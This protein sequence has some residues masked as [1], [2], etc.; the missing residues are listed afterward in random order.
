MTKK[1]Y[2]KI[3][4]LKHSAPFW[5]TFDKLGSVIGTTLILTYTFMLG[6]YPHDSVYTLY[7]FLLPI[8]L[9][10]RY[11]HYYSMGWHYYIS[12]F[13]YY[14]NA[15][16]LYLLWFD[17]GNQQLFIACF[18]FGNGSLATSIIL[19]RL[20]LVNHKIDLLTTL[21]IHA[22]PLTIMWHARWFTIPEQ[23]GLD[24]TKQRFFDKITDESDWTA[25]A[26]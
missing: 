14:A 12:D 13:C 5:R 7:M 21:A 19:F 24:P 26:W 15:V 8:L 20:S 2:Q 25:Y 3:D 6:R 9:V 11:L 22:L 1:N 23:E 4:E 10:T 17:S 16:I 18:L